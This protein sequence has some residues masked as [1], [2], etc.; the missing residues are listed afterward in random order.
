ME[1]SELDLFPTPVLMVKNFLNKNEIDFAYNFLLTNKQW[2]NSHALISGNSFSSHTELGNIN[3][4]NELAN[5]IKQW[6]FQNE[7]VMNRLNTLLLYFSFKIRTK[8]HG[9]KTSWFNLQLEGSKLRNHSHYCNVVGSIYLKT[10]KDSSPLVIENPSRYHEFADKLD[11]TTEELRNSRYL[12]EYKFFPESGDLILFPGYLF[13][14]SG[15]FE[16]K[17]KERLVISFNT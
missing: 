1:L 11:R 5:N 9:I 16:N 2:L 12:S 15:D 3:I 14:G 7:G 13:H 17:S 4:L 8:F 6:N 10:D